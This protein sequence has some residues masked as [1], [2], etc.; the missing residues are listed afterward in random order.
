LQVVVDGYK[1]LATPPIDKDGN[2]IEENDYR[3]KNVIH[4]GLTELVYTKIVDYESAKEIWE[5]LKNIYEGDAKV[6]GA[7]LQ[8]FRVKFKQLKMKEDENIAS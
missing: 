1:V 6:K 5:K 4:N 3:A 8:T 2:K 7:K